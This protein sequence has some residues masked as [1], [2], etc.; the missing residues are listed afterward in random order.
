LPVAILVA[1]YAALGHTITSRTSIQHINRAKMRLWNVSRQL[2]NSRVLSPGG[3]NPSL[4]AS[5]LRHTQVPNR[6][7]SVQLEYTNR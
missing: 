3:S 4:S 7:T 6:D 1:I 2:E 5:F